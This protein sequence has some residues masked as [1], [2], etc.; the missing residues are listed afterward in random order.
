LYHTIVDASGVLAVNYLG[1][2]WTEAIIGGFAV[3]S[4]V[5]IFVLRQPEP[6]ADLEPAAPIPPAEFKPK[7]V[8]ETPE[9]LDDTRYQ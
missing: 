9:K 2:S 3:L 7:P 4:L 5:I 1:I 6:Q 8:E